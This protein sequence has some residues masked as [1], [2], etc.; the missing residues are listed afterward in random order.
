MTDPCAVIFDLDGVLLDSYQ[1]H[2]ESWQQ[3]AVENG[4]TLTEA[5]FAPWFGVTG[6]DLIRGLLA[7]EDLSDDRV[8]ALY[9]RKTE[10][11]REGF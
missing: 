8:E 1:A 5:Q 10:L 4:I 2:L 3:L 11:Y 6:R 7:S 9:A